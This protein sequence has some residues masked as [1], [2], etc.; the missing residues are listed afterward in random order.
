MAEAIA[1]SIGGAAID[2]SSA[3]LS[4]LGWVAPQTLEA[5]RTLG[6]PVDGLSSKG[7]DR[8]DFT[9]ID[10]VV[11][12]LGDR[13]LD[14]I[15]HGLAIERESWT[16]ADPFGEDDELYLEVARELEGR[17]HRLLEEHRREELFSS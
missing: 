6:H 7:L 11:S 1:R 17:I 2:A 10:V 8:I 12:L 9:Q 4:P 15:P 16:I 5:L 3:G 14:V 13:G